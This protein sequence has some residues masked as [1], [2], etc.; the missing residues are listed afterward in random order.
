MSAGV[1][2]PPPA[3]S[4]P[5]P[6]V[7]HAPVLSHTAS[8]AP[9]SAS[10]AKANREP[11]KAAAEAERKFR[12]RLP[13]KYERSQLGSIKI[14]SKSLLAAAALYTINKNVRNIRNGAN[15]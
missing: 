2:T 5:E 6:I 8:D 3:Q 7:N 15:R 4:E 1:A 12:D 9:K 14:N 13:A 10:V 11:D